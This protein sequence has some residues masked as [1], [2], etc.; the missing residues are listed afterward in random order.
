LTGI[1]AAS[2]IMSSLFIYVGYGSGTLIVEMED[3]PMD[4]GPASHV[5]IHYSAIMIHRA[6]A[7]NESGWSTVSAAGWINLTSVLNIS[8]VISQG[9]LQAGKYNVIRFNVTEAIVTVNGANYTA[10][11]ASGKLNIPITRG[12]IQVNAGQTTYLVIDVAPRV[13]GSEAEGFRLVPSAKA[14]PG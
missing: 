14:A 13:T 8:K 12:G 11:V 7:A 10:T 6:D 4:W 3:P 1:L 5:Y 9:P 2:I